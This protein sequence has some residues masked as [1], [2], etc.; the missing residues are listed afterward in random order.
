MRIA[1]LC[2]SYGEKP[3]FN[4]LHLFLPDAGITALSG[5]SGCGKTTL[6]RLLAG[7]EAPARGSIDA[8][9]PGRISLLF[10]ENRLI[11]GLPAKRQLELVTS[12]QRPASYWLEAVGLQG[13]ENTPPEELSGGMQRRLALARCLAYGQDKE[14]LLLD[15]PFTG[16]D[17]ERIQ[18]LIALIRDLRLPVVF[19][20]HDQESL[21][22]ADRI[23]PVPRFAVS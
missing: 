20:A 1:D 23:I 13:E 2:F 21:S 8:P 6:L 9:A 17:P 16:V 12:G 5:P 11:P 15:E 18:S 22:M 19:T 10:Q 3:V 7:L 14:L 4:G